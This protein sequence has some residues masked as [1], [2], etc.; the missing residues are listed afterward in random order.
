MD[1]N[2]KIF[3]VRPRQLIWPDPSLQP[4]K[5]RFSGSFFVDVGSI[6]QVRQDHCSDIHNKGQ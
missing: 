5:L 4:S 2:K 3:R 6:G 1:K